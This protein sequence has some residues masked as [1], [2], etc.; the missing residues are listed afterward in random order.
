VEYVCDFDLGM[1]GFA[2]RETLAHLEHGVVTGHVAKDLA[3]G[4][5]RYRLA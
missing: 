4:L 2:V 1:Q 3:G 5:Y